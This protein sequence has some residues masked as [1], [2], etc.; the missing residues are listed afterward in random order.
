MCDY[1]LKAFKKPTNVLLNYFYLGLELGESLIFA[2]LGLDFK[3]LFPFLLRY[4]KRKEMPRQI[5]SV[6]IT[7]QL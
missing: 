6:K 4:Y 1:F 2:Q 7:L 3:L 5:N